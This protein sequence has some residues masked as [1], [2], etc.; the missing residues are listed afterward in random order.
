MKNSVSA[1]VFANSSNDLTY[2]KDRLPASFSALFLPSLDN[3]ISAI[4]DRHPDYFITIAYA[5][6]KQGYILDKVRELSPTTT[7]IFF[8]DDKNLNRIDLPEEFKNEENNRK[9]AKCNYDGKNGIG[10][11]YDGKNSTQNVGDN[12]SGKKAD[13]A[14]KKPTRRANA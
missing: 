1:V 13:N 6:I 12:C 5:E 4:N 10:S 14:N 3:A 7:C 8:T 11:N 9:N 2:L